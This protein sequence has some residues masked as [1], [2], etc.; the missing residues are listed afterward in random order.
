MGARDRRVDAYIARSAGFAHPILEHLRAIVHEACPD[1]EETLKWSLPHF[2]YHGGQLCGM[3]AFQQHCTFG[4]RKGALVLDDQGRR[5]D[6][7]M[8]QFGRI[9]SVRDLPPKRVLA[10]YVKKAMALHDEGVKVPRTAVVKRK[11]LPVPADL[12]AGLKRN[13]RARA[14]FAA[15]AP[16]HRREYIEWITEAK[17]DETRARRLATTLEWLAQGR[18]RNWKHER[19]RT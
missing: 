8:G 7:A 15:L 3:A 16:S 2:M 5:A 13:A 14:T 1:A 9:T 6:E 18:S 10:R 17:R 4:F 11:P 19:P 12:A